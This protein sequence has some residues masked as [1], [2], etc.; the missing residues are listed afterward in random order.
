MKWKKKLKWPAGQT[1]VN[2]ECFSHA[3]RHPP[4]FL[5]QQLPSDGEDWLTLEPEF[6]STQL[7]MT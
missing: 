7:K 4:D 1:E 2:L 5:T 3:D 6:S